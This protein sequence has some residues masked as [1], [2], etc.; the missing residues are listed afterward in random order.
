MYGQNYVS[1]KQEAEKRRSRL[2]TRRRREES[3]LNKRKREKID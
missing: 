2:K 3:R 1:T